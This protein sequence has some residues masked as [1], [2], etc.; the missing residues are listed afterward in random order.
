MLYSIQNKRWN[1]LYSSDEI[2]FPAW[3]RDSKY[4]FVSKG[5]TTARSEVDRIHVS[6]GH[7]EKIADTRSIETTSANS[8]LKGWFALTPDD[9]IIV[10]RDRGTDEVYALDL[11]YR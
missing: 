3:S 6:D 7:M 1:Q 9:R 2:G 10:M 11:A 4:V 5:I 8:Q